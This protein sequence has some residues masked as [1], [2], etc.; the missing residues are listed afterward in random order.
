[1]VETSRDW[2]EKLPFALWAYR[3]SFRNSAGATP[4]SLVY[5][6]EAVLP[7]K[8]DR[9]W[10][11]KEPCAVSRL[12]GEESDGG[13][14]TPIRERHLVLSISVGLA[15]LVGV[16]VGEPHVYKFSYKR[17][18]LDACIEN[19]YS[20]KAMMEGEEEAFLLFSL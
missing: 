4:Y 17:E 13:L 5:G 1:M 12:A 7:F 18:F 3:T 16:F 10:A 2:S 9:W 6:M 19:R 14:H 8:D 15:I 11:L 20:E